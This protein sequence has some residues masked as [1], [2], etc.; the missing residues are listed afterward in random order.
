MRPER[1]RPSPPPTARTDETMPTPTPTFSGGNSSLMIAKLSGKTAPPVP[2]TMRK[3][4]S[5]QMFGAT[6]APRQPTKKMPRAITSSRSFPYWSPSLPSS[7]VATE[8]DSR[9]PVS[10]QVA[11]P[12]VV[13]SSSRR[14]GRAGTTIVCWSAKAIPARVRI[15]SV[16]L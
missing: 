12:V 1:T 4:I 2:C 13:C 15:A 9:K 16:T 3:P 11:Q 5:T 8:A 14:A 10:S 7:G 6:A